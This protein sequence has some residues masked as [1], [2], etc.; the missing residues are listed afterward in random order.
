MAYVS[1]S[2]DDARMRQAKKESRRE[3]KAIA[4]AEA[5]YRKMM[6]QGL[7][8]PANIRKIKEQIANKTG[9]YPMGDTN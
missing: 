4:R 2:P 9:A 7:V 5:M 8:S 1:K 3:D 6:E